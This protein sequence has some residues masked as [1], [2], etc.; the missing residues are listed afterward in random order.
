MFWP[1]TLFGAL[2]GGLLAS[3]PGALLGA[4]IGQ[5]LDRRL[6]LNSWADLRR[7][8]KGQGKPLME[9]NELLF[10]L[11]GRLAKSGGRVREEHIQAAGGEVGRLPRNQVARRMGVDAVFRGYAMSGGRPRAMAR[12]EGARA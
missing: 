11:L 6:G 4:L 5:M 7:R 3:I 8:L 9:G 1:I 10:F 2:V 12:A